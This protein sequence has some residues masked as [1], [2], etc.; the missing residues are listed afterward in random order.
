MV[1]VEVGGV[2]VVVLVEVVVPLAAGPVVGEN[3]GVDDAAV[4][5]DDLA[6]QVSDEQVVVGVAAVPAVGEVTDRVVPFTA[7]LVAVVLESSA[8]AP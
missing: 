5:L 7:E 1:C 3:S 2:V 8:R 4:G 6:L